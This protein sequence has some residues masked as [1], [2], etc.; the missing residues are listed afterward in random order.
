LGDAKTSFEI[1]LTVNKGRA[2]P[3]AHADGYG[4]IA[5]VVDDARLNGSRLWVGHDPDD[6]KEFK[7]DGALIA[8]FF[9]VT[10]PDGYKIEVLEKHGQYA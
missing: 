9:F 5:V 8:R 7:D 3:Y 1:E 10:D 6:V 4:H 2:E